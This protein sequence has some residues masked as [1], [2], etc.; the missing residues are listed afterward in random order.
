MSGWCRYDRIKIYL[1]AVLRRGAP[2]S[3]LPR[4]V[5]NK[6]DIS[7]QFKGYTWWE[8]RISAGKGCFSGWAGKR[9]NSNGVCTVLFRYGTVVNWG[10]V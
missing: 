4:H 8:V 3:L 7:E 1:S 5:D 10:H 2:K 9:G 6:V